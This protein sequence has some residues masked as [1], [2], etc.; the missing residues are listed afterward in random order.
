M[1]EKALYVNNFSLST[2]D[3]ICVL[4]AKTTAP[5]IETASNGVSAMFGQNRIVDEDFLFMPY[6]IAKELALALLQLVNEQ[7]KRSGIKYMLREGKQALW[8][9]LAAKIDE[10]NQNT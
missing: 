7:E 6:P 8:E 2:Q 10:Y 9:D 5:N 4:E 1:S 3:L